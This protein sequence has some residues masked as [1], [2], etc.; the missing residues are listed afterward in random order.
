MRNP[1]KIRYTQPTHY[2]TNHNSNVTIP[3]LETPNE[4]TVCPSPSKC[5]RKLCIQPNSLF[6]L[7]DTHVL[8]QHRFQATPHTQRSPSVADPVLGSPANRCVT[9]WKQNIL[10]QH[11]SLQTTIPCHNTAFSDGVRNY[12][13]AVPTQTLHA[14]LQPILH[15]TDTHVLQQHKVPINPHTQYATLLLRTPFLV[16]QQTHA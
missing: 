2:T 16:A 9:W 1:V 15:P 11:A 6:H 10:N 8:Q 14:A 4:T 7:T 3:P 12:R 5:Q 13:L